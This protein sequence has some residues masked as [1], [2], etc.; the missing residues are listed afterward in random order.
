MSWDKGMSSERPICTCR[1]KDGFGSIG[2]ISRA[3]VD[4]SAE[5][6]GDRKDADGSYVA[7]NEKASDLWRPGAGFRPTSF[8]DAKGPK[9]CLACR[10]LA[11]TELWGG[12]CDPYLGSC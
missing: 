3:L 11:V 1:E 2:A 5:R 4:V 10:H 7:R 12:A 9:V 8:I 6:S